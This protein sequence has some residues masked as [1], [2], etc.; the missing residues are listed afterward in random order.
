MTVVRLPF[1]VV[2]VGRG[3]TLCPDDL[4]E[5]VCGV[6]GVGSCMREIVARIVDG[7]IRAIAVGVER[8]GN[9]VAQAVCYAGQPVAAS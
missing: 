1:P 2:A 4:D 5:A 8:I 7:N 6:I 3:L 9:V